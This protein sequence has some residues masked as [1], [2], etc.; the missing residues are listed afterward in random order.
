V[1]LLAVFAKGGKV[2]LTQGERN[3]LRSV[4]QEIAD[5]YK[6]GARAH[7]QRRKKTD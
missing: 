5:Y 2:D 1:F 7:V 6:A 3:E 4:L